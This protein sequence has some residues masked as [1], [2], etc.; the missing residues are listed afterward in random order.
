MN[1]RVLEQ[2]AETANVLGVDF[3]VMPLRAAPHRATGSLERDFVQAHDVLCKLGYPGSRKSAL[4][5]QNAVAVQRPHDVSGIKSVGLLS[6]FSNFCRTGGVGLDF[7]LSLGHEG[8]LTS[9]N[10]I[11]RFFVARAG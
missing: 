11:S 6:Y 1:P 10:E 8:L 4:E 7:R 2:V 3:D 5:A 9:G